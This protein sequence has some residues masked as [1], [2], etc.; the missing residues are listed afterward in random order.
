MNICFG[1]GD[2]SEGI[3]EVMPVRELQRTWTKIKV[4]EIGDFLVSMSSL[5]VALSLFKCFFNLQAIFV[6]SY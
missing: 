6:H 5:M 4:D 1:R 3:G 2:A